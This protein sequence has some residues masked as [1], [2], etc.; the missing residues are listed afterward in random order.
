MQ[1]IN[2]LKY[3][4]ELL[5]VSG[6]QL[7]DRISVDRTL[8]S[9]WKNG[10]RPFDPSIVHFSK[11]VSSL[12]EINNS[13]G[14]NTLERFFDNL[15]SKEDKNNKDWLFT[16]LRKWLSGG[17]K[18][19][20]VE[21]MELSQGEL[22]TATIDIYHGN[23]G[24]RD[25][26][27]KLLDYVLSLS[28]AQELLVSDMENMIW[29]TE[30]PSYMIKW[31]E[32]MAEI[33]KN[34]H[35]IT[36]IHNTSRDIESVSNIVFNW[37]PLYF[38]GNLVSYYYQNVDNNISAPSVYIIK[39]HAAILSMCSSVKCK[40]RY[41]ALYKDPFSTSQMER[42]FK[43]RLSVSSSLVDLFS[44]TQK[45]IS[46]LTQRILKLG[47]KNDDVYLMTPA[48]VFTTMSKETLINVLIENQ[49]KKELIDEI[50]TVHQG[51]RNFFLKDI[52]K[53]FCR[54]FYD[55]DVLRDY[56]D[57][58]EIIYLELSNFTLKPV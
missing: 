38:S 32:K 1:S 11:T 21:P 43:V 33:L 28:S 25:A 46:I 44:F 9:K 16:A 29:L 37:L 54:Q 47:S 3:I 17:L 53:Y 51:I 40:H 18:F 55:L 24:K 36:I 50:V 4:M 41:T 35:H 8:V 20:E 13:Q 23:Q 48:P 58:D 15:V 10:A 30:N 6:Q 12:I 45:N 49:I 26:I 56:A 57:S 34:G 5:K 22:Y 27:M 52:S 39:D 42:I 19:L 2:R 7:A 31:Q 14:I